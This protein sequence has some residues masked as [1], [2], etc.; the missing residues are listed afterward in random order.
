MFSYRKM[1]VCYLLTVSE[2]GFLLPRIRTEEK[3]LQIKT[4]SFLKG[5]YLNYLETSGEI[6][7]EES[8]GLLSLEGQLKMVSGTRLCGICDDMD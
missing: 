8:N 1:A 2:N 3:S 4:F 7:D 6:H 5:V